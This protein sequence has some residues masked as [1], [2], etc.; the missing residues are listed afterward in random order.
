MAFITQH[1]QFFQRHQPLVIIFAHAARVFVD[2]FFDAGDAVFKIEELV[3]L[4]FIFGKNKPG[5]GVINE[6]GQLV[7]HQIAVKTNCDA[8]TGVSRDFSSHPIRSVIA[9]NRDNIAFLNAQSFEPKRHAPHIV[10]VI[11]PAGRH[12][13]AQRFLAQSCLIGKMFGVVS[14][15]TREGFERFIGFGNGR[16]AHYAISSKSAPR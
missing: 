12:P 2:D 1:A 10:V 5:L 9:N 11:R 16:S 3:D 4:L 7:F 13:D 6:I 14:Q 15:H 8:L